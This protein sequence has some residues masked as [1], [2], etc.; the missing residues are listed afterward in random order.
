M[1]AVEGAGVVAVAPGVVVPGL[2]IDKVRLTTV[3]LPAGE[4]WQA[5]GAD[6]DL[7]FMKAMVTRG[8]P[9]LLRAG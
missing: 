6:P 4:K 1:A 8:S 2:G 3:A 5:L 7:P 9:F